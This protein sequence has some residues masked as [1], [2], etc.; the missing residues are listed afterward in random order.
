MMI[1]II[2]YRGIIGYPQNLVGL[3]RLLFIIRPSV[4][5]RLHFLAFAIKKYFRSYKFLLFLYSG[6]YNYHG[7]AI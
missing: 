1:I 4:I 3:N 2:A 6:K 5:G 7:Q